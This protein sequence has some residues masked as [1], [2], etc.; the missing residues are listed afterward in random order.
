MRLQILL[1]P[2]WLII[3]RQH[4]TKRQNPN[5]I[6]F[7][8]QDFALLLTYYLDFASLQMSFSLCIYQKFSFVI[9]FESFFLV[10]RQAYSLITPPLN[11][12][13]HIFSQAHFQFSNH[14]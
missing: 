13:K 11:W 12:N 8:H 4:Q 5:L 7:V 2:L 9:M 10:I 3:A 6:R 1:N 14:L